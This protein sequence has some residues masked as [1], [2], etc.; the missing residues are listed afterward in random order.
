MASPFSQIMTSMCC[1]R[2]N[3]SRTRSAVIGTP[4]VQVPGHWSS[5]A[6]HIA[7][8]ASASRSIST[9]RSV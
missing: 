5:L 1:S 9:L 4:A 7:A 6:F 8:S 3:Q 2:A